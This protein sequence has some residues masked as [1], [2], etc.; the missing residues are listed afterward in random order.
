MLNWH[1]HMPPP[2]DHQ[3]RKWAM[4]LW[5]FRPTNHEPVYG[6]L[7]VGMLISSLTRRS[8]NAHQ[9]LTAR[10]S[11]GERVL[12]FCSR[13]WLSLDCSSRSPVSALGPLA[14]LT[15]SQTSRCVN[16]SVRRRSWVPSWDSLVRPWS[17]WLI[18]PHFNLSVLDCTSIKFLN[19]HTCR[20]CRCRVAGRP[21]SRL[22]AISSLSS[23]EELCQE[24]GA[25]SSASRPP[26]NTLLVLQL[27]KLQDSCWWRS[28]SV[29]DDYELM[30]VFSA[31]PDGCHPPSR[32]AGMTTNAAARPLCSLKIWSLRAA[33][34]PEALFNITC[35]EVQAV[36]R[37]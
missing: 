6:E 19:L 25:R 22:P 3:V 35:N 32:W 7:L 28:R 24:G 16:H 10:F 21:P 14:C 37:L 23:S 31:L 34:S 5:V 4:L 13:P 27:R 8:W 12:G 36:Q 17:V 29:E 30:L 15:A 33:H 18:P 2:D 26:S 20:G 1:T 11:I 9:T